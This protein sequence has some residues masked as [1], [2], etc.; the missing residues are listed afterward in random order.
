[1][2]DTRFTQKLSLGLLVS[3]LSCHSL[4][5]DDVGKTDPINV[6][7]KNGQQLGLSLSNVEVNH[8]VVAGDALKHISCTDNV[9]D[10]KNYAD[11][12]TGSAYVSIG[13]GQPFTMHLVTASNR[14]FSIQVNPITS[15]GVTYQF[16]PLSGGIKTGSWEKSSD[17][18]LMLSEVLSQVVNQQT[19]D[20]FGFM[21]C[22]GKTMCPGMTKFSIAGV[23]DAV[24]FEEFT[25]EA[26]KVQAYKITNKTHYTINL[27]EETLAE[28]NPTI[29]AMALTKQT[30]A[31]KEMG[32]LYQVVSI[33]GGEHD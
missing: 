23:I 7:F 12:A 25:G 2:K 9:C 19:P 20:D 28:N 6:V 11:D 10:V 29:R 5:A 26:L 33:D 22:T 31:P 15:P 17:Y 1:M 21:D 4:Y 14:Y 3:I 27:Y 16:Q 30:L 24:P 13:T 32:V 18:E 8:L